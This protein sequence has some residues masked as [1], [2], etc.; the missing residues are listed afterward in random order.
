MSMIN[1]A[2]LLAVVL[3]AAHPGYSQLQDTNL[4][5][6]VDGP[7]TH[8]GRVEV[9]ANGAWGTICDD[10]F[11][12]KEANVICR[13]LGYFGAL[14]ALGGAYYGQGRGKILMDQLECV[15]D[16]ESIFNCPINS[17]IGQH[18]CTHRE[19]A[20]V[21]CNSFLTPTQTNRPTVQSLPVRLSCPYNEPCNNIATK[22]GPDPGECELSVHV[23]GIVQVYY[24]KTW[25]Y[26]SANG[27][28][29]AD[30]DVVCG[31]LGYPIAFGTVSNVKQLLPSDKKVRR[32]AKKEFNTAVKTVLMKNVLCEGTEA[33]L[34][35]CSHPEFGSLKN[36]GGDVATAR[37]GFQKHPSCDKKCQVSSVLQLRCITGNLLITMQCSLQFKAYSTKPMNFVLH[38]LW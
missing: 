29:K 31:Q 6:L 16:E 10:D 4:V 1:G 20:G 32:Q 9:Y 37:C 24:N 3:L 22:R 28:D 11:D 18:D 38:W 15:G 14:E 17:T 35:Q 34:E 5:R 19:D 12:I 13:M 26:I 8:E 36:R 25:W 30:V 23:E 2:M 27:W 7:T 33:N 21:E